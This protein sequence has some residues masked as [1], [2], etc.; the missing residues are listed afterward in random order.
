MSQNSSQTDVWECAQQAP[1]TPECCEIQ[2]CIK[3]WGSTPTSVKQYCVNVCQNNTVSTSSVWCCCT[4]NYSIGVLLGSESMCVCKYVWT[5]HK[6]MAYFSRLFR[7]SRCAF[8]LGVHL[9]KVAHFLCPFIPS[10]PPLYHPW[11]CYQESA[12]SFWR[13]PTRRT[14]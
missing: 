14:L 2:Y 5:M 10:P 8:D 7:L 9:I 13:H 1:V 12:V 11:R 4:Q 3:N 6:Y